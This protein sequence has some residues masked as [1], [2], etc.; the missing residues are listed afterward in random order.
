MTILDGTVKAGD[1]IYVPKAEKV[2]AMTMGAVIVE[3]D[4]RLFVPIPVPRHVKLELFYKWATDSARMIW[5]SELLEEIFGKPVEMNDIAG[6]IDENSRM[7]SDLDDTRIPLYVPKAEMGRA[8][9]IPGVEWDRRRRCYVADRTADLG[10]IH[11]YLT[12]GMRAV[13]NLERNAD[14]AMDSLVKAQSMQVLLDKKQDAKEAE[15]ARPS[16]E[17]DIG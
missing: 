15:L 5:V 12:A 2:A 14:M 17:T 4:A 10:L 8:C 9:R 11:A 6:L 7:F 13:W 1:P 16:I 3:G